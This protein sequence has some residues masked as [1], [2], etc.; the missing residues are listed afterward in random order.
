[1]E[2][3]ACE[4]GH[5]RGEQLGSSP[6]PDKSSSHGCRDRRLP[7]ALALALHTSSPVHRTEFTGRVRAHAIRRQNGEVAAAPFHVRDTPDAEWLRRVESAR[8]RLAELYQEHGVPEAMVPKDYT[9]L[10]PYREH[11]STRISDDPNAPLCRITDEKVWQ[12]AKETF[13]EEL[14][15]GERFDA[16]SERDWNTMRHRYDCVKRLDLPTLATTRR[17]CAEAFGY[18]AEE[19]RFCDVFDAF[20]ERWEKREFGMVEGAACRACDICNERKPPWMSTVTCVHDGEELPEGLQGGEPAWQAYVKGLA[21][22]SRVDAAGNSY[23]GSYMCDRCRAPTAIEKQ[24][25]MH[26]FSAENAALLHPLPSPFALSELQTRVAADP[27][28]VFAIATD[29]EVALVR[30]TIPWC[31]PLR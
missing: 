7:L 14:F 21:S 16:T 10:P 13:V 31:A 27:F 9:Q 20:A 15:P 8:E 23:R 19:A 24:L 28:S 22:A 4:H 29:A 30:L 5:P 6:E 18:T 12:A 17:D 26:K 1:M 3:G 2:L 11:A 25:G